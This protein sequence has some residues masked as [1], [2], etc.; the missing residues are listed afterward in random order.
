M[1]DSVKN[2]IDSFLNTQS[3][4]SHEDT[5][6]ELDQLSHLTQASLEPKL[7]IKL[8]PQLEPKLEVKSEIPI[9]PKTETQSPTVSARHQGKNIQDSDVLKALLEFHNSRAPLRGA[10]AP[11]RVAH[12][13]PAQP[14]PTSKSSVNQKISFAAA[15]IPI[16]EAQP[17][18]FST[19]QRSSMPTQTILKKK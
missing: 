16:V 8:E 3:N 19:T 2:L 7:E 14:S 9:E 12:K 11:T 13:I 17:K 10:K 4:L 18:H 1:G 5:L 6:K 15:E